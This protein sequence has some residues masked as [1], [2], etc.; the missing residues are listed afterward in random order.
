MSVS[1]LVVMD[2]APQLR[3]RQPLPSHRARVSILVVMDTAPQ[4]SGRRSYSQHIQVSIL[5]V[6]DTAPQPDVVVLIANRRKRSFNPC[7]YGYRSSTPRGAG[8]HGPKR[9]SILVVMD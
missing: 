3:R 5:V 7:C 6:M 9:V 1:I 2:T 4:R 8:Q